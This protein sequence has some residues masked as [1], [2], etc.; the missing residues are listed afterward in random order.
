M[1]LYYVRHGYPIYNP[2][3]LTEYG[4]RQAA[5][6]AK[7]FT[8]YGLDEI[9]SSDSNRAMMTAEPT[10]KALGKEM[11]L[12]PWMHE[13]LAASRFWIN[14]KGDDGCWTFQDRET[15]RLFNT[16]EM[17]AL[18]E[19]W[20]THPDL[21]RQDFG[22]G[23]EAVHKDVDAFLLQL[24]FEHIRSEGKYRVVEKNEK[25]VA[26]FAHQGA[27][28]SFLSSLL[29]I[30]YPMFCTHFDMGHS[31]VTAIYFNEKGEDCVPKVL[32]LSN[33]SHLYKEGELQGYQGWIDI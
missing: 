30:P 10:C 33:D 9:Y 28:M 29:D 7:R 24:G 19:N 26:L 4:Q 6:L 21:P 3:G 20:H 2:D 31:S 11:T 12:C 16:A 22:E 27:G 8:L 23:I 1:I 14:R 13:A 15:I 17:R 32:Q 25:R 5:A 18:G